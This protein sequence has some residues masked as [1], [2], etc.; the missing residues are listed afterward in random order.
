[1]FDVNLKC[2]L[3]GLP[4]L[5][6][7]GELDIATVS[8]L[9]AEIDALVK[10]GHTKIVLDLKNMKF[11]DSTGL[12]FLLETWKRLLDSGGHLSLANPSPGVLHTLSATGLLNAFPIVPERPI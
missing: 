11:V 1:M 12:R 6:V 9:V 7:T 8:R 4:V 2:S 5:E 3:E 10:L